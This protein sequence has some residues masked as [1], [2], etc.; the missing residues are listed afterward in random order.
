MLALK[1]PCA[2]KKVHMDGGHPKYVLSHPGQ[3]LVEAC[4]VIPQG[5]GLSSYFGS[6]KAIPGLLA[7]GLP[8]CSP[9]GF[10]QCQRGKITL[11]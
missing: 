4:V 10:P 5:T 9:G 1:S 6:F 8:A 11:F 3:Q 2:E 7:I